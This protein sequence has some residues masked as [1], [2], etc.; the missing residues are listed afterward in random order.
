[1]PQ[2]SAGD[3]S[4]TLRRNALIAIVKQAGLD[5]DAPDVLAVIDSLATDTGTTVLTA[6][7]AAKRK[8]HYQM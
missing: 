5:T 7:V 2:N 3:L 8:A 6:I 4:A 1:M